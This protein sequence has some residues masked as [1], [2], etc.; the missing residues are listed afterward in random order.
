MVQGL[1]DAKAQSLTLGGLLAH[2]PDLSGRLVGRGWLG[3]ERHMIFT[4]ATGIGKSTL[5]MQLAL[6]WAAGSTAWGMRPVRPLRTFYLQGEGGLDDMQFMIAEI[7]R[8]M[9]DTLNPAKLED[10]FRV[11][12]TTDVRGPALIPWL[13][14]ALGDY[15]PDLIW[16]DPLFQFFGG[17][18][19]DQAA[20][21]HFCREVLHPFGVERGAAWCII[22]HENKPSGIAPARWNRVYSGSG[23]A[24][25]ANWCKASLSLERTS[26]TQATLWAGKN[27]ESSGLGEG[28]VAPHHPH[29]IPLRRADHARVW[30]EDV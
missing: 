26:D 9:R 29:S 22:H 27:G 18:V 11:A 15:K 20:V 6:M 25:S 13:R 5:A 30:V 8:G 19:K 14:D 7:L 21:T 3:L 12:Y 10:N 2:K 1:R 24:D 16:M 23:S 17:D 28:C 4:G